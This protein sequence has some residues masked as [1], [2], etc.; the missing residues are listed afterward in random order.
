M[1]SRSSGIS[2]LAV[3]AS[4]ASASYCSTSSAYTYTNC[5]SSSRTNLYYCSSGSISSTTSG[6]IGSE[7][8]MRCSLSSARFCCS[9]SFKSSCDGLP[10]TVQPA[11]SPTPSPTPAPCLPNMTNQASTS[12]Q[13]CLP[14]SGWTINE[15]AEEANCAPASTLSVS[16]YRSSQCSFYNLVWFSCSSGANVCLTSRAS[17]WSRPVPSP[18]SSPRPRSSDGSGV[19]TFGIVIP[20]MFVGCCITAYFVRRRCWSSVAKAGGASVGGLVRVTHNPSPAT[21]VKAAPKHNSAVASASSAIPPRPQHSM[22]SP[23]APIPGMPSSAPAAHHHSSSSAGFGHSA[24]GGYPMAAGAAPYPGAPCP[25][26]PGGGAA[27]PGAPG[28]GAAYPGAPGGGAAYPGAPGGG[29]AYP[30]APGGGAAYP[31]APGGGAAYPGAPGGGAAYPGA[32]GG[33]AAYPG[34][35]GGGGAYPTAPPPS[36]G[37]KAP[38]PPSYPGYE[39]GGYAL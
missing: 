32:P 15:L 36:S 30:G 3:C 28:G 33:G 21:A 5:V 8:R 25:G 10:G 27:Y 17:G 9:S 31:G 14:S 24:P 34:A 29:A 35:P 12:E 26:A 4:V 1:R 37:P 20:M 38:P 2:L 18:S 7:M 11:A 19:E 22:A 39:N 13:R 23:P 6:C 16:Q